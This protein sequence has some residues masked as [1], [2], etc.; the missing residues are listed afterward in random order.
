MQ[1]TTVEQ[2]SLRG[3]RNYG[4]FDIALSS[5]LTIICGPNAVGKTTIIEAL[6]MLTTTRSFRRPSTEDMIKTG[7]PRASAVMVSSSGEA[8]S[9]RSETRLLLERGKPRVFQ[10]DRSPRRPADVVGKNTSVVFTPDDLFM[11]KGPSES[12]RSTVD[13][14]GDQLSKNYASMRREYARVLRSRN[15]VLKDGDS[16]NLLPVLDEQLISVGGKLSA[17]RA[18][19]VDR[20]SGEACRIYGDLSGRETMTARFVPSWERTDTRTLGGDACDEE[21][22]RDSIAS[23][24]AATRP[25]EAARTA[26]V[27]GPHRDDIRFIVGGEEARSHASQ[28]Q[29]RTAALSW[30]LAEVEVMRGVSGKAPLVMLD[31]VMSELDADRR[32]ALTGIVARTAQTVITTTNLQYFD[33]DTLGQAAIVEI[34]HGH[35]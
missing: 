6:Q 30:K 13:E 29:Q 26:T 20:L 25:E 12:R 18:R 34:S 24:L 23:A 21:V 3:F 2:L 1:R 31:D 16:D 7:E 11:V 10:V 22:A 28:G 19:L 35:T 4:S 9:R 27:V 17:A 5:G 8:A 15:R 33:E 32:A 14:I